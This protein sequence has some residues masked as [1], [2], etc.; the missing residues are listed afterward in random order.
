MIIASLGKNDPEINERCILMIYLGGKL[1][2]NTYI[3][4]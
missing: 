1:Y 3:C 4:T 2:F